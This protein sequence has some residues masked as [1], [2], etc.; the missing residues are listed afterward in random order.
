MRAR[1]V[2]QNQSEIVSALRGIGVQVFVASSV[3]EGLPDLI[4]MHRGATTLVEVKNGS[5]LTGAQVWFNEGAKL[6]GVKI[7]IVNNVSEA[8]AIFGA[9]LAA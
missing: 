7:H 1:K 6:A 5:K 3:G 2:D 4:C 9:R 8:L